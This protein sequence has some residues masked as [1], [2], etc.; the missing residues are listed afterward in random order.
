MNEKLVCDDGLM[1]SRGVRV[2]F[3]EA[4]S[5]IERWRGREVE[6]ISFQRLQDREWRARHQTVVEGVTRM[7]I[8]MAK[9]LMDT[10]TSP[11]VY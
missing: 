11:M 3:L 2:E 10:D 9:A 1:A 6:E 4:F 8:W 7:L 5:R